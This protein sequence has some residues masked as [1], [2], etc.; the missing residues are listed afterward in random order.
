MDHPFLFWL[1][2]ATLAAVAGMLLQLAVAG[3]TLRDLREVAP[4]AAADAPRVTVVIAARDEARGI[5]PALRSVLA[6]EGAV[7]VV[8][9]DDRST[10]GTGAILDRMAGA[11]PRLHVLHVAEL[12]AGWL[13]K[14][15]ALHLGAQAARGE[16]LCFTD[17]D[18]VMRPDT[19]LRATAYLRR[20]RLDHLTIAP[21]VVM[22]GALLQA[23][24]VGFGI[25]FAL[26]ARPWKARDPRSASH[27]G[28]G[29]FNLL[30]ADAYCAVGTHEAIRMRPDDDMKLGKLVKKHG[31][32]QDFLFGAGHLS[33]EWYA[34]LSEAV[35]GLRK[36]AFAGVD[37]RLGTVLVATL[38]QLLVFIVPF[39][40]LLL[41]T[42]AT[43]L[44]YAAAAAI[45]LAMYVGAARAQHTPLRYA[46]LFPL[47]SVVFLIALWNSTLYT[48]RRGGIEWRGTHYPLEAL[49]A[50]RV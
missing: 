14:N 5:E 1:A 15:H 16:L 44:L 47:T 22:P 38:G 33:V 30:R 28:I 21:R 46:V 20:E 3:R 42:G 18:V 32:A 29:A 34:S 7:E 25:F 43:R 11:E 10:D 24:G 39:P 35:R 19:L 2:A 4:L 12:P 48:L 9:V 13:G 37:Y 23:F 6:L 8:V 49:R 41:T 27:V 50:N 26:F 45:L 40:A 31:L 36:N 17:A